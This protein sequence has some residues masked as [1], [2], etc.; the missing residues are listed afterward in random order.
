MTKNLLRASLRIEKPERF[1]IMTN[2]FVGKDRTNCAN[3]AIV[4]FGLIALMTM[5]S[6]ESA[7]STASPNNPMHWAIFGLGMILASYTGLRLWM[8]CICFVFGFQAYFTG[9][10]E[11]IKRVVTNYALAFLIGVAIVAW[12]LRLESDF[13]WIHR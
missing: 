8:G 12:E 9:S 10:T 2:S 6:W 5:I 13:A 7:S 4:I 3:W 11:K 1:R